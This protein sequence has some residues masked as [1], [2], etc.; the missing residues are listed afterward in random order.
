MRAG[1]VLITLTVLG[2]YAWY[3]SNVA[4][5]R[6]LEGTRDLAIRA[7][8]YNQNWVRPG[9]GVGREDASRA[10]ERLRYSLHLKPEFVPSL[11]KDS[12]P[13]VRA[14]VIL[15]VGWEKRSEFTAMIANNLALE[16]DAKVR[17]YIIASLGR[18][19]GKDALRG[20]HYA[21]DDAVLRNKSLAAAALIRLGGYIPKKRLA[22]ITK[23]ASDSGERKPEDFKGVFD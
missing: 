19:G 13:K 9:C 12:E 4:P 23:E 7:R 10:N 3:L 11:V 1:V 21:L 6:T 14:A 16:K 15:S 2:G 5:A 17:E 22:A 18:L 20:L 8:Q